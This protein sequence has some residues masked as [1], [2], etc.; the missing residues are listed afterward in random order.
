MVHRSGARFYAALRAPKTSRRKNQQPYRAV[1]PGQEQRGRWSNLP[2]TYRR[3]CL[4]AATGGRGPAIPVQNRGGSGREPPVNRQPQA[5]RTTGA[6]RRGATEPE[7][8]PARAWVSSRADAA[9]HPQIDERPPPATPRGPCRHHSVSAGV[10]GDPAA[11]S[12][13]NSETSIAA[14]MPIRSTGRA[15]R[16]V[17]QSMTRR[18][19]QTGD[20]Q[21]GEQR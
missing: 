10:A 8:H 21:D 4:A 9:E 5:M 11:P 3:T 17:R 18:R 16:C 12:G 14:I 7:E 15:R 2:Q 1:R 19:G 20:E 6:Y 13:G